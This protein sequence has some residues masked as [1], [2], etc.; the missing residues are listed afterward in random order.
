MARRQQEQAAP[1]PIPIQVTI[2]DDLMAWASDPAVE[3]TFKRPWAR[4]V[5]EFVAEG[6][7]RTLGPER[8][9]VFFARLDGLVSEALRAGRADLLLGFDTMTAEYLGLRITFQ[10]RH[11]EL[12]VGR[13]GQAPWSFS[14]LAAV[15]RAKA[16]EAFD[17]AVKAKMEITEIFPDARV[18]EVVLEKDKPDEKCASCGAGGFSVMIHTDDAYCRRCYVSMVTTT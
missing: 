13:T 11:G 5:L 12:D 4:Q 2:P 15:I 16:P 8:T 14:E 18:G 17:A 7:D 6:R 1:R 10:T 9:K 3:M